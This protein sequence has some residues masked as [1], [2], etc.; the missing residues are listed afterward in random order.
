MWSTSLTCI[1]C[2]VQSIVVFY[3]HYK[4]RRE[5]RLSYNIELYIMYR[6]FHFHL[7]Q[8]H[9]LYITIVPLIALFLDFQNKCKVVQ[10]K[11][12]SI[13]WWSR[14]LLADLY[15]TISKRSLHKHAIQTCKPMGREMCYIKYKYIHEKI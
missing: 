3:F 5:V 12:L 7:T 10:L 4:I 1:L 15:R 11:T 13:L 9:I 14:F 2:T 8:S 6:Y